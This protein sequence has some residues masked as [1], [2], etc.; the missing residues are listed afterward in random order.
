MSQFGKWIQPR[1]DE[2]RDLRIVGAGPEAPRSPALSSRVPRLP[3]SEMQTGYSWA[4]GTQFA[5][6]SLLL[7]PLPGSSYPAGRAAWAHAA[8]LPPALLLGEPSVPIA[9]WLRWVLVPSSP[10]AGSSARGWGQPS[11]C[12]SLAAPRASQMPPL[13][14]ST[15][16][17][18]S[19]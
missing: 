3:A 18:P 19:A 17:L 8:G 7:L 12:N 5:P 6:S 2:H 11:A 13:P 16:A 14:A 15:L 9:P 10:R 4:T 1:A